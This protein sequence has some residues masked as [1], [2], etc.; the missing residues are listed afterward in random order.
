[1]LLR[2][3]TG[4]TGVSCPGGRAFVPLPTGRAD[5]PRHR[6]SFAPHESVVRVRGPLCR[7]ASRWRLAG[8]T[9]LRCA[10]ANVRCRGRLCRPR[11]KRSLCAYPAIHIGVHGTVGQDSHHA[12]PRVAQPQDHSRGPD[13]SGQ[14]YAR[15]RSLARQYT[16]RPYI[17]F[18]IGRELCAFVRAL[19]GTPFSCW[20]S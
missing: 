4:R 11:R 7:I 8:R 14:W 1:M 6:R 12:L 3:Q 10:L 16:G 18:S 2:T 17:S 13:R 15:H 5:L 9:R 19:R 20:C